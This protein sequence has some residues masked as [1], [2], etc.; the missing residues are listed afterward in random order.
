MSAIEI[1]NRDDLRVGDV[2]TFTYQGHEFTGPLWNGTRDDLALGDTLV[3]FPMGTWSH[4][5]EFV[6]A[7]R[8][9]P[10]QPTE[11][12]AVILVSECRG[13]RLDPPVLAV[14]DSDGTWITFGHAIA[15]YDWHNPE[16]ITAWKPAK[17]IPA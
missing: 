15:T 1:T 9:V 4:Y 2:A 11:P 8:E 16:H 10:D 13:E 12:G 3:R 7:T 6:R 14:L 5:F 17:V